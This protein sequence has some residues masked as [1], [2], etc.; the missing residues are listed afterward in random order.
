M[1]QEQ[2][3]SLPQMKEAL[4]KHARSRFPVRITVAAGEIK[5]LYIRGFADAQRNVLLVSENAHTLAL[6]IMEVKEINTLEFSQHSR[7]PEW[8]ILRAG[9]QAKA[10]RPSRLK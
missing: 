6:G 10:I 3:V 8:K 9:W 5:V 4:A 1:T 7:D 2:I